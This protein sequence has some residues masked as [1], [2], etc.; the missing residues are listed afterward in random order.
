MDMYFTLFLKLL[1]THPMEFGWN[2][3]ETGILEIPEDATG[4]ANTNYNQILKEYGAVMMDQVRVFESLHLETRAI[5][6]PHCL[7]QA[8]SI[9]LSSTMAS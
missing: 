4:M 3:E 8:S 6:F 9:G 1:K 7:T 2:S 5:E